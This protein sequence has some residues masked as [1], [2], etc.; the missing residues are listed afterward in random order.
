MLTTY[1]LTKAHSYVNYASKKYNLKNTKKIPTNTNRCY[2][3]HQSF[4][5]VEQ[6]TKPNIHVSIPHLNFQHLVTNLSK[7]AYTFAPSQ[8]KK[9]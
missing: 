2:N 7:G 1:I 5:Q 4:D 3:L 8:E 6:H 9:Y